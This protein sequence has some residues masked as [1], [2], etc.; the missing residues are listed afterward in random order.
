MGI[1]G[2]SP[3]LTAKNIPHFNISAYRKEIM[4]MYVR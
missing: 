1:E 4:Y 2:K 3:F